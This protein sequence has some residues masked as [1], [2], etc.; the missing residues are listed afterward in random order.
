[1][2]LLI[3]S[4]ILF[5]CFTFAFY[6]NNNDGDDNLVPTPRGFHPK[7]CVHEVPSD[8]LATKLDDGTIFVQHPDG[9]SNVIPICSSYTS[10]TKRVNEKQV[11]CCLT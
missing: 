3:S 4:L 9:S 5:F 11:C 2:K 1:M 8:S 10:T 6:N 7:E